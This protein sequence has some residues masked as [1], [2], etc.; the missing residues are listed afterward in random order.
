M[1]NVDLTL[2]PSDVVLPDGTTHLGTS[3]QIAKYP[4]F[5]NK[6]FI[7]SERLIDR[8]NLTSL[9]TQVDLLNDDKVHYRFKVH[10]SN[11]GSSE[12]SKPRKL[13][14]T[15]DPGYVPPTVVATPAVRSYVSYEDNIDGELIIET[16]PIK[17][18]LGQGTHQSTTY[19]VLDELENVI[20]ST[21]DSINLTRVTLNSDMLADDKLYSVSVYHT[22]TTGK[23]SEPG[24][25]IVNTFVVAEKYFDIYKTSNL[26]LDRD[27]YFRLVPKTTKFKSVDISV[28][29]ALTETE[30]ASSLDQLSLSPSINVSGLNLANT[31]KVAARMK[32]K[33]DTYTSYTN[34]FSGIPLE[35]NLVNVV[36]S[37]PYLNKF[38]YRHEINLNGVTVQSVRQ[39]FD[40]SI[41]L[42]KQNDNNIY[43]Y[44][45]V[46]NK[47][48]Y[49]GVAITLP[50][51]DKIGIPYINIVQLYNGNVLINYASN[52]NALDNQ[53]SV[54]KL[55]KFD[56]VSKK[57]TELNSL[58]RD[59]EWLST[60]VS[61][62][63]FV[64]TDN[65]VYYVPANEVDVNGISVLA[66]LHKLDTTTFTVS[67]VTDL[68]FDAKRHISITMVDKTKFIVYGGSIDPTLIN[69]IN[70]WYRDNNNIY[71]YDTVAGTFTN[72]SSFPVEAEN[73]LYNFQGYLRRDGKI[74]MFNSVRNGVSVGDQRVIVFNPIDN[75]TVVTTADYTDNLLYRS[76][77]SLTNGDIYRIL[78]ELV[79]HNTYIIM[80]LT[81]HY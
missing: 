46:S 75:T 15:P 28:I 43:R 53:K 80:Y 35:N 14:L 23:K 60:A 79:I 76:S 32:L 48:V 81:Q 50:I 19:E 26:I 4:N 73:T 42:T 66:S 11:G 30:V 68:P 61:A 72:V 3:W 59:N 71:L 45:L 5:N 37:F 27:L 34:I 70:N 20:F 40:G 18:Y 21:T 44:T 62:S 52:S 22:T 41:L 6:Y 1:K 2:N 55:F 49:Q 10:Y 7:I 57:F 77:I 78:L 31:Y 64:D 36:P 58:V 65:N 51:E 67:K 39:L 25:A 74:A 38:D 56:T 8:A 16:S 17:F 9:S 54:F 24:K 63:T 13:E 47:L 33:D 69:G 12:W 29:D